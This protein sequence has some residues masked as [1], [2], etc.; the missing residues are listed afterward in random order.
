MAAEL[1]TPLVALCGIT[2]RFGSFAA[3][4]AVDLTIGH[5]EVHALLGENGAG[6]STLVKILYGLLQPDEGEIRLRG[7]TIKLASP[8]EARQRGIGMVFQHFSLF[9][10]MSVLENI[11]LG[12]DGK[13]ADAALRARVTQIAAEYGLGVDCDR[14]VWSLSAGERQRI[15]I[16]R[17]LLQE[18]DLIVLDE[19]TSVLTPAESEALF[20]TLKTLTD[21]GT[22]I[23][24]ISHKLDEVRQHC[25]T[26]TILRHGKVVARCDPRTETARTLAAL[27]VGQTL[28]EIVAKPHAVGAPMLEIVSVSTMPA[29]EH[30]VAVTDISLSV[31]A[32]EIVAVAG[33]AGNGQ[34]E[35]FACISGES[36]KPDAGSVLIAGTD[37]SSLA[38]NARRNLGAVFVPE[39]RL[40]HA[41]VPGG[42]LSA[43]LCLTWHAVNGIARGSLIDWRSVEAKTSEVMS[44]FDV[45]CSAANPEARRLS[46]GNLQKFVVGRDLALTPR[47]IVVNQPSW[48]IDAAAATAIRQALLDCAAQGAAILVISQDLDEILEIADRIAVIA[49]G[50]LSVPVRAS[51]TNREEIGLLMTGDAG[52]RPAAADEWRPCSLISS[53]GRRC[54]RRPSWQS[55]SQRSASPF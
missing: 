9:N 51:L 49:G 43:N 27:M 52:A 25:S 18:P 28:R 39:E 19:P 15:E 37:A 22:S 26:A 3:N 10:A 45:R 31:Q 53:R 50:R 47:L 2:K 1:N 34:S 44:A 35:L 7:S 29:D 54:I 21:R 41:A 36:D 30:S 46:G 40:G 5:G 16:L 33:I 24:L 42:R 17:C 13:R 48:G 23:L 8:A 11:A 6:K 12:C 4:D 32:G 14:M 55:R 38:I 20:G